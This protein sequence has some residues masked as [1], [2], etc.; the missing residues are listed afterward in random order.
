MIKWPHEPSQGLKCIDHHILLEFNIL[1]ANEERSSQQWMLCPTQVGQSD[2]TMIQMEERDKRVGNVRENNGYWNMVLYFAFL[3]RLSDYQDGYTCKGTFSHLH[4]LIYH[5]YTA[6]WEDYQRQA[7]PLYT[8]INQV[9]IP[10]SHI[11]ASFLDFTM[12]SRGHCCQPTVTT[13]TQPKELS[14]L[15]LWLP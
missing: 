1:N 13:G 9:Q 2:S 3:N 10:V 4:M 6:F 12:F 7:V 5:L 15:I 14:L 11:A 8:D